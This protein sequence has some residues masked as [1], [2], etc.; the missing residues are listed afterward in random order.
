MSLKFQQVGKGA[1]KTFFEPSEEFDRYL[2]DVLESDEVDELVE[3]VYRAFVYASLN[4]PKLSLPIVG[5][6]ER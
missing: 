3:K 4:S 1:E 5:Y 2:E 6:G